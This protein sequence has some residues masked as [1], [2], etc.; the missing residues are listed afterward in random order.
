VVPAEVG[1]LMAEV[2]LER[3]LSPNP[4]THLVAAAEEVR[5]SPSLAGLAEERSILPRTAEGRIHLRQTP[6]RSPTTKEEDRRKTAEGR[7]SPILPDSRSHFVLAGEAAPTRVLEVPSSPE[8]GAAGSSYRRQSPLARSTRAGARSA[9]SSSVAFP[10]PIR[11][12]RRI[13]SRRTRQAA[14]VARRRPS[15]PSAPPAASP[16]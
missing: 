8:E 15:V 10:S 3:R 6:R 1:H 12:R 9:A 14:G 5:P 13:H 7:S 4:L 16:G 11:R 2:A